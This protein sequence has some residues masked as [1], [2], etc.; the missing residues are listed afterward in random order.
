[1]GIQGDLTIKLQEVP[2][3]RF[4]RK[5]NDLFIEISYTVGRSIM[6]NNSKIRTS[7]YDKYIY[8]NID[9]IIKPDYIMKVR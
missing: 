5:N 7:E 4:K 6:W 1:M 8:L 3:K 2:H 9:K